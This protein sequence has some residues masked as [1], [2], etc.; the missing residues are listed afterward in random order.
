M[1]AGSAVNVTLHVP[2]A[3]LSILHVPVPNTRPGCATSLSVTLAVPG[4]GLAAEPSAHSI[5]AVPLAAVVT[6]RLAGG[7]AV[8]VGLRNWNVVLAGVVATLLIVAV[9]PHPDAGWP[10]INLV[11]VT[12]DEHRLN[13][14][15]R[16]L[17]ASASNVVT[18]V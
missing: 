7:V 3:S 1:L 9:M 17:A 14:T 8:A 4:N 11:T 13:T 12:D 2:A 16:R 10:S 5:L 6:V 15:D 18:V